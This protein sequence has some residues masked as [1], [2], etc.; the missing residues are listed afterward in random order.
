[1]IINFTWSKNSGS[2]ADASQRLFNI[3]IFGL[4]NFVETL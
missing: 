4:D 2:L 1:M 3:N